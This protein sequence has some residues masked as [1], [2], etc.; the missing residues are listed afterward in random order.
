MSQEQVE[1]LGPKDVYIH[2]V[3]GELGSGD[4][5]RAAEIALIGEKAAREKI[6]LLKRYAV[7][8]GEYA[9]F[10]ARHRAEPVKEVKISSVKVEV[11]GESKISPDVVAQRLK[12]KPGETLDVKAINDKAGRIFGM[13]DFE[14]VDM[15]AK[16]KAGRLRCLREG[17]GKVLGTELSPFRHCF[18]KR[19]RRMEQVQ[20]PG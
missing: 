15:T 5:D 13:G 18:G 2:P 10:T 8:D 1:S 19:L 4:F 20:H 16:R 17:Q 3:L 6:E 12:V 7:A 11:T 9:A 14:R